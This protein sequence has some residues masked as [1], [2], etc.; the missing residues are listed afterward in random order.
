M[1]YPVISISFSRCKGSTLGEFIIDLCKI[2]EVAAQVWLKQYKSIGSDADQNSS[3]EVEELKEVIRITKDL[4]KKPGSE[5]ADY[6]HIVYELFTSLS[7]FV[8]SWFGHY[9]LLVDEYDM[10]FVTI[11]LSNWDIETK[12]TAR[13]IMKKLYDIMIKDNMHMRKGLLVGVFEFPMMELGSGVNNIVKIR[14]VPRETDK[15]LSSTCSAL[16]QNMYCGRD[17]LTDAFWFNA[18]EI[19]LILDQGV[20]KH[21]SIREHRSCIMDTLKDWYNGYRIG[22][23]SGKY[24]PWSVM[25]FIAELY[26]ELR[27][28]PGIKSAEQMDGIAQS[29]AYAFWAE[30]GTTALI[31]AQID[32]HRLEFADLARRLIAEYEYVKAG[33]QPSLGDP[34][35]LVSLSDADLDL[36]SDWDNGFSEIALL[37]LCLYAGYLTRHEGANVCI[38]N[39]EVYQVWTRLFARAVMGSQMSTSSILRQRGTMI[40]DFYCGKTDLLTTLV[41]QTHGVLSNHGKYM[42]K[43]YANL[44]ANT[45]MVAGHFGLLTHPSQ[46]SVDP[47][48]AVV[49]REAQAGNGRCDYAMR[50]FG[51]DE[52]PNHFGVII[53]FKL[54]PE[55]KAKDSDHC[56]QL[57]ANALSQ[58]TD[59]RYPM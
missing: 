7:N 24:N 26:E 54:I 40:Q 19:K 28:H 32:K 27:S 3:M 50:L 45:L 6:S 25:S 39:R 1:K 48:H 41:L 47:S 34:P 18:D 8:Y 37:S 56:E 11:T 36:S 14:T 23:F 42:E 30:T 52:M 13:K 51:T 46:R 35:T 59:K 33:D 55:N 57:A 2:I 21:L 58:I 44:V 20:K 22:R 15:I 31:D 9:I 53:E 16:Y 43:D 38:P 5:I 10:P 49:N 12:N 4:R 17:A 29:A